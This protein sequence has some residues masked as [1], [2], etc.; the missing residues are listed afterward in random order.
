MSALRNI[1]P[2]NSLR[3]VAAISGGGPE[4]GP[5]GGG[6]GGGPPA[7][8]WTIR[9]APGGAGEIGAQDQDQGHARDPLDDRPRQG[10]PGRD[11]MHD[12]GRE[13]GVLWRGLHVTRDERVGES[14]PE[15][16]DRA[17]DVQEQEQ[18]EHPPPHPTGTHTPAGPGS[19]GRAPAARTLRHALGAPL[20]EVDEHVLA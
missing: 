1:P 11:R 7:V 10:D 17:H 2:R 5:S 3:A 14:G 18:L 6:P 13:M 8:S 15:G 4:G 9:A 20:H 16:D 19:M 12:L